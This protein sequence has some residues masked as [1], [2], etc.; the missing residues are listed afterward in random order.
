MDRHGNNQLYFLLHKE[1]GIY[2]KDFR[3]NATELRLYIYRLN[4]YWNSNVCINGN[5]LK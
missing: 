5:F 2:K 3:C 4:I 1:S